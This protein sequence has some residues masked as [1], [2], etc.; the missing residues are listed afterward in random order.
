MDEPLFGEQK[1]KVVISDYLTFGSA[2]K[3][4]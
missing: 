2:L 4:R 1:Q 3:S